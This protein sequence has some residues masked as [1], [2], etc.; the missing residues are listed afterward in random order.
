MLV[1]LGKLLDGEGKSKKDD[2]D[3]GVHDDLVLSKGN[4][5]IGSNQNP[6]RERSAT[7]RHR[8]VTIDSARS[9]A[10]AS[11]A[12]WLVGAVCPGM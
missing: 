8:A 11:A 4:E 2:I 10:C 5:K 7:F 3:I 6:P 9:A 1:R 12:V